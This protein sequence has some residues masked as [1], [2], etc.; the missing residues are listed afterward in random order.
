V[1]RRLTGSLALAAMLAAAASTH[2]HAVLAADSDAGFEEVV[3]THNPFSTASHLHAIL[4]IVPLH[5][6]WACAWSRSSAL[7]ESSGL[8]RPAAH[9]GKLNALPPRSAISVARFTRR[10]R[11]PPNLF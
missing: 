4:Q 8:A 11:A 7:P 2:H 5:P 3:T 6:C 10:S 9:A 1:I